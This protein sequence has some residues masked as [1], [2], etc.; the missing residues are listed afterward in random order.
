MRLSEIIRTLRPAKFQEKA[1]ASLCG[2]T[3]AGDDVR[4]PYVQA[5]WVNYADSQ[6]T[7]GSPLSLL[8]GARTQITI[9]GLGATTSTDYANG[10]HSDVWAGNRFN[11]AAVGE[12]YNVRLTMT[13]TQTTS[14]NGHH[15]TFEADIGFVAASQS[16]PLIKGQDVST[17]A[18]L[19]APFF[20][21]QTF[22][23]AGARFYITPSTD[24][25][26]HSAAVF[27]QRTFKP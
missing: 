18:T 11:P 19:S 24:V 4:L 12:A 2:V 13:I 3:S 20:C 16:I 7:A 15:A 25:S 22:G 23:L 27:I 6:Y 1:G 5:G 8:A 14:G 10:M 17:I 26:L 9:D 21:L